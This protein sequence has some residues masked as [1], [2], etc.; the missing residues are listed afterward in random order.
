MNQTWCKLFLGKKN[1]NLFKWRI[2]FSSKGGNHKNAKIGWV[3][4]KFLF[5]RTTVPEKFKFTWKL[6]YWRFNFVKIIYYIPISDPCFDTVDF[7]ECDL[8]FR[9]TTLWFSDDVIM[10]KRKVFCVK[11][12]QRHN[13]TRCTQKIISLHVCVFDHLRYAFINLWNLNSK[14]HVGYII[15]LSL[16]Q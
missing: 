3:H 16:L 1:S 7:T 10:Q 8:I 5:S 9:F 15:N 11:R 12:R 13:H 6:T 2:S 14:V 4:L